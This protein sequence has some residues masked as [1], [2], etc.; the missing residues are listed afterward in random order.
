MDRLKMPRMSDNVGLEVVVGTGVVATL[1]V[2]QVFTN[3]NPLGRCYV[4]WKQLGAHVSLGLHVCFC[5]IIDP[6][7]YMPNLLIFRVIIGETIELVIDR[8]QGH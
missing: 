2:M 3:T 1:A 4:F 6:P 7:S 8:G 5:F